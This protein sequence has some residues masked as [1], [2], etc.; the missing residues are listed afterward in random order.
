M[1]ISDLLLCIYVYHR[2]ASAPRGQKRVLDPLEMDLKTVAVSQYMRHRLLSLRCR[3]HDR[4]TEGKVGKR[5]EDEEGD[6][7]R[8]VVL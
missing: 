1:W 2:H 4:E 7:G 5:V 6:Q 3:S 8:A